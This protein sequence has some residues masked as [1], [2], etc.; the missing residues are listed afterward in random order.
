MNAK[1]LL[2]VLKNGL[3]LPFSDEIIASIENDAVIIHSSFSLPRIQAY[4]IYS[5]RA[6]LN[7]NNNLIEGFD[8]LMSVLSSGD[9]ANVEIMGVDSISNG[10]LLFIHENNLLSVIKLK[11]QNIEKTMMWNSIYVEKGLGSSGV[12]YY[13]TVLK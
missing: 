2:I 4:K 9:V 13:K 3:K 5:V 1:Q 8:L 12:Y 6:K 7:K 10:Y 11:E